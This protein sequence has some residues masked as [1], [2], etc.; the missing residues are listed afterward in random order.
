[1]VVNGEINQEVCIV[2]SKSKEV[3]SLSFPVAAGGIK[4]Q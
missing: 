2:T 4:N 1:M 3:L